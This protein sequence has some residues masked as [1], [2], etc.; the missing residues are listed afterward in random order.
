MTQI[1]PRLDED[2]AAEVKAYADGLSLSFGTA[3][4]V[5][6]RA[7]LRAAPRE[8]TEIIEALTPPQDGG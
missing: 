2:V 8:W 5:L 1:R 4:N 6:I 3:V 7:G